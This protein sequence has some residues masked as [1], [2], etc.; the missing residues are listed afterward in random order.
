MKKVLAKKTAEPEPVKEKVKPVTKSEVKKENPQSVNQV[1][2]MDAPTSPTH[3]TYT[4]PV[5]KM[6]R[7]EVIVCSNCCPRLCCTNTDS[8]NCNNIAHTHTHTHEH[9]HRQ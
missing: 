7:S 8:F 2:A 6:I 9:A 4:I 1:E 5:R 3:N